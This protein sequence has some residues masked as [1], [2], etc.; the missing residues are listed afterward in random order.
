MKF[1]A[2]LILAFAIG[3]GSTL[4]AA[5]LVCFGLSFYHTQSGIRGPFFLVLATELVI[6]SAV[7]TGGSKK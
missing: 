4:L 3:F 7:A 6:T 1:I 5:Q 2:L